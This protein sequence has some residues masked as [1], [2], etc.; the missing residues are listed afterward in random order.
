MNVKLAMGGAP[1][2]HEPVIHDALLQDNQCEHYFWT[3][4]WINY[5][6]KLTDFNEKIAQEF[7]CTFSKG[8]A[9]VK[10]LWVIA[11]EQRIVKVTGLS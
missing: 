6:L 1:I 7:M 5:I 10:G 11:T 2:H 3:Y 4:G 9:S 8:E